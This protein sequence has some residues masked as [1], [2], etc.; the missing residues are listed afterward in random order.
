[1]RSLITA[2][3]LVIAAAIAMAPTAEAKKKKSDEVVLAEIEKN[4]EV[5]KKRMELA[6]ERTG[7]LEKAVEDARSNV[8]TIQKEIHKKLGV[9]ER[10]N[11]L[12]TEYKGRLKEA[13]TARDEFLKALDKDRKELAL[14]RKDILI[15]K[16]KLGAL[17]AAEEALKESIEISEES[18][19]KISG[20]SKQWADNRG[21]A[22][23]DLKDVSQ[24]LIVLRKQKEEQEAKLK[25]N[26]A[27]LKKWRKSYVSLSDSLQK[28][29]LR[30]KAV[31]RGKKN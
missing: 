30:L 19:D 17:Q 18:L 13:G 26:Q 20:R 2:I 3:S 12:I 24:E 4:I 10:S 29:T 6:Q 1:M 8:I 16:K 21:S 27:S 23:G 7:S 22:A 31:Q 25:Q 9:Q 14:V 11:Q 28:L 15:A 5:T